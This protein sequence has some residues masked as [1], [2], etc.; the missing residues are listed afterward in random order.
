MKALNYLSI[1]L[2]SLMLLACGPDNAPKP[3]LFEEQRDA[4]EKAKALENTIQQQ[5]KETQQNLEN[6]PSKLKPIFPH[7]IAHEYRNKYLQQHP[8]NF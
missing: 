6:K 5:T 8:L 7:P 2:T 3:K 1:I 4:L